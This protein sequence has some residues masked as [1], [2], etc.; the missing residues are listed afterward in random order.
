MTKE[1]KE[2]KKQKNALRKQQRLLKA[3]IVPSPAAAESTEDG[4][5]EKVEIP[6]SASERAVTSSS[7][8]CSP[9]K[10]CRLWLKDQR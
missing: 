1:D 6:S 7:S 2:D 3:G 8:S 4:V 5:A 10:I 9:I